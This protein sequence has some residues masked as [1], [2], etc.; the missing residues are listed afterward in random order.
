VSIDGAFRFLDRRVYFPGD[1]LIKEGD[2]GSRAYLIEDGK[3]E[4]FRTI[5]GRKVVLGER[6]KGQILGEM[7]L[8]DNVGR[9]ASCVAATKVTCVVITRPEFDKLMTRT[10]PLLKGIIRIMVAN[11]RS[12]DDLVVGN[13]GPTP[14]ASDI[15]DA[16]E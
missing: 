8:I 16:H 9:I 5:E 2:D 12:L 11:V 14:S 1:T 7:A 4:V 13:D 10:S 6:G 3:V 15:P